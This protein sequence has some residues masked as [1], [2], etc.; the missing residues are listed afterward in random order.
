MKT[1]KHKI[2]PTLLAASLTFSL[3]TAVYADPYKDESGHGKGNKNGNG[4]N[5]GNGQVEINLH[6]NFYDT[7]NHWAGNIVKLMVEKDIIKGYEDNTFRPNK[8]VTQLEAITMV[9]NLLTNNTEITTNG[10]TYISSNVP[11]WA[12]DNVRLA[13]INGIID[14]NDLK[15]PNKPATRMFVIKLLVNALGADFEDS[16]SNNLFFGDTDSLTSDEKAY[17]SFALL[18]SLVAGY[19]DKT[20]KPN[21]PVT[22]AE[23]AIFVNRLLGKVGD[24]NLG[25]NVSGTIA[26]IN[27]NEEELKIGS[28]W[29]DVSSDVDVKIDGR[30]ADL[31]DLE[32]GMRIR[33]I[34]EDDEIETIYA[35]TDEEEI[36]FKVEKIAD[37]E[38]KDDVVEAV[39]TGLSL[40][41]TTPDLSEET[42]YIGLNE[43]ISEEVDV[44]SIDGTE[45]DGFEVAEELEEAI[46]DALNDTDRV[47]VTFD[48]DNNR[49]VFKTN[50]SPAGEVP[51]IRFEGRALNELGLDTS[52]TKGSLG[53]EDVA[54]S[55][56]ITVK[57]DASS[58]ETYTIQLKDGVINQ[59]VEIVVD[60][61]DSAEEIA[62]KIADALDN[63][64]RIR[65]EYSISV[66]DEV[67]ALTS[68][69]PGEDLNPVVTFTRK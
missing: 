29:Y 16:G 10:D 49:F 19:E 43:R 20:F 66:N 65:G 24:I 28:T 55:F 22:R 56:K 26:D 32:E 67:V 69:H 62:D 8:P 30:T 34:F 47:L 36:E 17:L 14:S 59:T 58:D 1:W 68:K 44:S 3:G 18:Q 37:G 46:G 45:D 4:K 51:S 5:K 48:D 13:L 7:Q 50:D 25:N 31:D 15:N 63:N 23:M 33:V 27:L 35:Y 54:E 42:L 40:T 39:K 41:D 52:L 11:A 61:E 57:S 2:I 6:I 9:M 60:E 21:K 53:Q 12:K 38:E 64:D